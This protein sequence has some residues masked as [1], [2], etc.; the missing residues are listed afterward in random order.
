MMHGFLTAL[1]QLVNPRLLFQACLNEFA[2]S[3]G[4]MPLIRSS[5]RLDPVLFK[6]QVSTLRKKYKKLEILGP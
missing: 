1:I 5:L 2:S 6:D 3:F 4:Y